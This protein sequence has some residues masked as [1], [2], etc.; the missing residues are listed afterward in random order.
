[1]KRTTFIL[2]VGIALPLILSG[3]SKTT[4]GHASSGTILHS[5][6]TSPYTTSDTDVTGETIPITSYTDLDIREIEAGIFQDGNLVYIEGTVVDTSNTPLAG[7][8]IEAFSENGTRTGQTLYRNSSGAIDTNRI[9][10][11]ADGRF[12]IFNASPG[13]LLLLSTGGGNGN[14][15]V[16]VGA[17]EIVRVTLKLS[18]APLLAIT[19]TGLTKNGPNTPGT[20]PSAEGGVTLSNLG[21]NAPFPTSTNGAGNFSLTSVPGET[22]TYYKL[23]KSG[24]MDTYTLFE[25]NGGAVDLQIFNSTQVTQAPFNPGGVTIDP[26]KGIVT[27]FIWDSTG[28]NT[29][30]GAT[31]EIHNQTGT[32]VAYLT[33]WFAI[34]NVPPGT[35]LLLGKAT[36]LQ[37]GIPVEV[38]ADSVTIIPTRLR[39][40]ATNPGKETVSF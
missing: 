36:N 10:T 8:R 31:A 18:P 3:C 39:L 22:A 9:S 13:R 32:D 19:H 4:G 40:E 2:A 35:Q 21:Q 14:L 5:T 16:T 25:T 7:A 27:G 12:I 23:T 34:F 30:T 20:S 11:S 1:M 33:G 15:Y 38:F 29:I 37:K 17:N 28:A 26:T 24:Y 6:I